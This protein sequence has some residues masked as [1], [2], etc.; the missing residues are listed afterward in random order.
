MDAKK[1]LVAV[2]VVG[3]IKICHGEPFPTIIDNN[4]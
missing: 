4:F 1:F 3:L 2:L